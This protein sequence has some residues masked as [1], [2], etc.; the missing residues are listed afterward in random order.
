MNSNNLFRHSSPSRTFSVESSQPYWH[1]WTNFHLQDLNQQF[2]FQTRR[3]QH[4][5]DLTLCIMMVTDGL[6]RD[7]NVVMGP[8]ICIPS[9]VVYPR[10]WRLWNMLRTGNPLPCSM[11][12]L[13]VLLW[14]VRMFHFE[15]SAVEL[16]LLLAH[17]SVQHI[18]PWIWSVCRVLCGIDWCEF[19][20]YP[21]NR[22]LLPYKSLVAKLVASRLFAKKTGIVR[23]PYDTV[24]QNTID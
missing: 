5:T 1:L 18:S 19:Q 3:E 8:A 10:Q 17:F 7:I 22:Q 11:I 13:M 2:Y 21:G 12:E 16:S 9:S 6:S 15:V 4:L 23:G 24:P 20:L 14:K